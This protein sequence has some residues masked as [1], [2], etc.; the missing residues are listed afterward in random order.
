MFE[1]WIGSVEPLQAWI[2]G[3]AW[4]PEFS[5]YEDFAQT[6]YENAV[7][8][9]WHRS[10]RPPPLPWLRF[11]APRSVARRGFHRGARSRAARSRRRAQTA[12]PGDGAVAAP[13]TASLRPRSGAIPHPAALPWQPAAKGVITA[14]EARFPRFAGSELLYSTWSRVGGSAILRCARNSNREGRRRHPRALTRPSAL[15]GDA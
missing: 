7:A 12:W 13:R 6:A 4:I 3:A 15:S 2:A 14:E 10:D 8:P 11:V 9:D 1:G 5:T